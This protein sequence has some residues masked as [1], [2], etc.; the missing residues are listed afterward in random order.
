MAKSTYWNKTNNKE[1]EVKTKREK[2]VQV[3]QIVEDKFIFIIYFLIDSVSTKV[4]F[5]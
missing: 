3:I 2:S 1:K 4:M 5:R